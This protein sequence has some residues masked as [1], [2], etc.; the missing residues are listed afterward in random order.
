VD[1]T[2]AMGSDSMA[3]PTAP[4]ST[5][6]SND[7]S[8]SA[9][10]DKAGAEG[11]GKQGEGQEDVSEL[12]QWRHREDLQLAYPRCAHGSTIV[13]AGIREGD[14]VGANPDT[15]ADIAKTNNKKHHCADNSTQILTMIGGFQG[16]TIADDVASIALNQPGNQKEW[17]SVRCGSAVGHRFGTA[18][19]TAPK[20]L[21][22]RK[23]PDGKASSL[24]SGGMI[25]YGGINM[26]ADFGDLLLLLPPTVDTSV[27]VAAAA[28]D[29]DK[30]KE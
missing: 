6:A 27:A 30:D 21:L 20:W 10:K 1:I 24:N 14:S 9:L 25:V 2:E 4:G 18:V 13:D 29:K 15:D 28:K 22:D 8:A 3:V 5:G 26:E 12:L 23:F 7:A 11:K 19:C 17:K 16:Q